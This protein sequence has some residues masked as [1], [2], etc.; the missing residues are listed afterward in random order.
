MLRA[1]IPAILLATALLATTPAFAQTYPAKEV[2]GWTVAASKDE[3]GCFLTRTFPRPGETTLLL[4][5]DI[6]QA[7][8]LSVLNTNW[9]IQPKDQ[10]KLN[11]RLNKAA[12]PDHLA[13]GI[14]SAGKKGFVTDFKPDF[15]T[16][17]AAS[18]TL[19]I[20]R[21]KVPVEQLGLT[22]SA[23]AIKELRRCVWIHKVKAGG[24]SPGKEGADGIPVDPFAPD[25]APKPQK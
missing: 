10:V 25:Q 5:L 19:A 20:T 22:G 8:R 17:F 14:E 3:R 15:L 24:G 9:S 4:G 12:Y 7:N 2:A 16:A 23:A 13:I 11:F 6:D 1:A 21:G 18:T